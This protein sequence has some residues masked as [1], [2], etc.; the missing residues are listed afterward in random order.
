VKAHWTWDDVPAPITDAE[1]GGSADVIVIGLGNSGVH[2]SLSS[3]ENGLSVI[4]LEKSEWVQVRGGSTG[5]NESHLH[6]EAN[7]LG[8][9]ISGAE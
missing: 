9:Y 2:T 7:L 4:A 3:V 8:K 1:D 5:S 6:K